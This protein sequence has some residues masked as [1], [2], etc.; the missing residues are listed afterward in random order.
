MSPDHIDGAPPPQRRWVSPE[1]SAAIAQVA[2]F[3]NSEYRSLDL[4][5]LIASYVHDFVEPLL[6]MVAQPASVADVGA[7]YGW[8]ALAFA[9]HTKA[10]VIVIEYDSARLAAARKIAAILGVEKNIEWISASIA[11][12]PLPTHSVEAVYCVEVIEHTGVRPAYVAE[13]ARISRDIV[14][15]TTPNKIFP[16]IRHDT[17][18]PFCHWLPLWSRNIYAKAFGRQSMQHGNQFWSPFAL[19][20]ALPNFHR[21]SRFLQFETYPDYCTAKQ[22]GDPRFG[23]RSLQRSYFGAV[24]KLGK[25]AIFFLPNLAST[26]RRTNIR[27]PA[28]LAAAA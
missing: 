27:L 24:S 11:D 15:I 19:L 13:L 10:H 17:V 23:G 26:F 7:G 20:R 28:A 22:L 12:I 18:L 16:I 5:R 9:L 3:C 8:L 4:D 14:V 25:H 21:T 6:R 2:H 1:Q